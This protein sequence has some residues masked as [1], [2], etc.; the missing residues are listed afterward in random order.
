[1]FT[2]RFDAATKSMLI[3][4]DGTAVE[5]VELADAARRLTELRGAEAV[6]VTAVET[7]RQRG[8]REK[9]EATGR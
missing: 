7:G 3:L 5:H 6:T 2:L 9:R 4:F 1:M 8:R